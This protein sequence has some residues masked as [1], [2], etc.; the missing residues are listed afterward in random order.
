MSKK[1]EVGMKYKTK[2]ECFKLFLDLIGKD[3][4][5]LIIDSTKNIPLKNVNDLLNREYYVWVNIIDPKEEG[6]KFK[7]NYYELRINKSIMTDE[8][9]IK[10]SQRFSFIFIEK[11]GEYKFIGL[12]QFVRRNNLCDRIYRRCSE[13]SF[14][15]NKKSVA[16]LIEKNNYDYI[17]KNIDN[18][19]ILKK[20]L[21]QNG[22]MYEF[23]PEELKNDGE[24]CLI[25]MKTTFEGPFKFIGNSLLNNK[26]F[27]KKAV[28][29]WPDVVK[30]FSE[31]IQKDPE[32]YKIATERCNNAYGDS[33]DYNNKNDLLAERDFFAMNLLYGLVNKKLR[34]DKDIVNAF[35]DDVKDEIETNDGGPWELTLYSIISIDDF[36]NEIIDK[37]LNEEKQR[38]STKRIEQYEENTELIQFVKMKKKPFASNEDIVVFD[39]D[40][41]LF[42]TELFPMVVLIG[43]KEN[44][45]SKQIKEEYQYNK[46]LYYVE[47]PILEIYTE[48]TNTNN[49]K[50]ITKDINKMLDLLKIVAYS[51]S[52][53]CIMPEQYLYSEMKNFI[54]REKQSNNIEIYKCKGKLENIAKKI[55][56]IP[57][58][59]E[60]RICM[61][62]IVCNDK[63][64]KY[65][66]ACIFNKIFY[67]INNGK[68]EYYSS[69][70]CE[71]EDIEIIIWFYK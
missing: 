44:A 52:M 66:I 37:F 54:L 41:E 31:E 11:N 6:I 65:A 28:K 27:A 32:V 38:H 42:A 5:S 49:C 30:Y 15:L 47:S 56:E 20:I 2:N 45:L 64:D 17:K 1:L 16:E 23:L 69:H 55:K 51:T 36:G 24:L 60:N 33:T 26:S 50:L 7:N 59:F 40:K 12:Y 46:K 3:I 19:K 35:W 63:I 39:F 43:K 8:D 62:Q 61:I 34:K 48:E 14:I 4:F 13:N 29:Q 21:R 67:E 53:D 18:R 22:E 71:I 9:F 70:A 57:K 68:I 25:A 58:S 10:T